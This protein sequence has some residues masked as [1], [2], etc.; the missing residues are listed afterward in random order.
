MPLDQS[1]VEE[2]RSAFEA[3]LGILLDPEEASYWAEALIRYHLALYE[4]ST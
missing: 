1:K 2:F 3:D 4:A